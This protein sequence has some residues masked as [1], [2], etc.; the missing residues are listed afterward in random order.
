MS[1][2]GST[3]LSPLRHAHIKCQLN[4]DLDQPECQTVRTSDLPT[5]NF[6]AIL[7]TTLFNSD[8]LDKYNSAISLAKKKLNQTRKKRMEI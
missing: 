3:S 8:D 1:I 4:P 5:I 6:E 7:L 2:T